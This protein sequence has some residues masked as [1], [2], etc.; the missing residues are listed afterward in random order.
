M[1]GLLEHAIESRLHFFPNGVAVRANDHA[2][3]DWRVIGQLGKARRVVDGVAG[4]QTDAR[5]VLVGKDSPAVDLFLVDPGVTMEGGRASVG[6]MGISGRGTTT[7]GTS[8]AQPS[9][10]RSVLM[11]PRWCPYCGGNLR[12]RSFRH[13]R[14]SITWSA[15]SSSDGGI[16]RPRALAVLVLITNS[17]VLACSTGRSAGFAPFRILFTTLAARR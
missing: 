3:F 2:A 6:A 13:W 10:G 16:V 17:N 5:T 12:R 14:H 9:S 8:I 1:A 4:D 11:I 15:R 7:T